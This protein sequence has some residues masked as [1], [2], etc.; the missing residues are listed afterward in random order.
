MHS[1]NLKP[2]T[3]TQILIA[4]WNFIPPIPPENELLDSKIEKS[5][6]RCK[7]EN[8]TPTPNL[9][10][11]LISVNFWNQIFE[12]SREYGNFENGVTPP[13]T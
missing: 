11:A 6:T 13:P 1:R 3:K 10:F 9:L 12:N 5:P 2:P 4:F 8:L 7:F